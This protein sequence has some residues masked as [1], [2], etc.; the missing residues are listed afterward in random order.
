MSDPEA[1]ELLVKRLED[2]DTDVRAVA[3]L[4]LGQCADPSD[5]NPLAAILLQPDEYLVRYAAEALAR[6]GDVAV[7]ALVDALTFDISGVRGNAAWALAHLNDSQSVPALA[8]ALDDQSAVVAHWAEV[9]L[10]RRGVGML[11]FDP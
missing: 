2:K 3:I 7:P 11:Y 8:K 5:V 9:A 10:E 1:T 4:A 6:L